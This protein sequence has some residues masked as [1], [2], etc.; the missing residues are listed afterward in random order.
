MSAAAIL[1]TQTMLAAARAMVLAATVAIAGCVQGVE[2][3]NVS[4]ETNLTL[5][6]PAAAVLAAE[7]ARAEAFKR[8]LIADTPVME[9][10]NRVYRDWFQL[11][12]Y[13]RVLMVS[14]DGAVGGGTSATGIAR[15]LQIA[16]DDC[17]ANR[18][19]RSLREP[20]VVVAVDNTVSHDL[21]RPVD[22]TT[23]AVSE[24]EVWGVGPFRFARRETYGPQ[25]VGGPPSY[26]SNAAILWGPERAKG[27]I[28]WSHGFAGLN[29]EQR[30]GAPFPV[31]MALNR[32]G[33]DILRFDRDPALDRWDST[34]S[35]YHRQ[36]PLLKQA[37]YKRIVLGGQSLGGSLALSLLSWPNGSM[38]DGV[39]SVAGSIPRLAGRYLDTLNMGAS[40]TVADSQ[41]RLDNW[42]TF[43]NGLTT[44]ARVVQIGFAG[45]ELAQ[46]ARESH[47]YARQVFPTKG[48]PYLSIV[49]TNTQRFNGH[50]AGSGWALAADYA[51]CIR[52]FLEDGRRDAS[53]R[54][55]AVMPGR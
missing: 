20:C 7:A 22:P 40:G 9:A 16:T 51:T 19:R 18:Q 48:I 49:P 3:G 37:G 38:I 53:C 15:A 27:V 13:N 14:A 39:L 6:P 21:S 17:N 24:G 1:E 54:A 25:V 55:D 46:F 29:R 30:F 32:D 45:D 33:W 42:R 4:P 36:L 8:P 26:G 12:G 35:H 28:I 11:V 52:V 50:G 44:K 10:A 2:F 34:T 5:A 23:A 47:D 31:V 41:G 43:V